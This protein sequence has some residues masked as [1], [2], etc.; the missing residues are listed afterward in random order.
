MGS[1]RDEDDHES[2][3]TLVGVAIAPFAP[4]AQHRDKQYTLLLLVFIL[5]R[6]RTA[7]VCDMSLLM[8]ESEGE[9]NPPRVKRTRRVFPSPHLQSLI[10]V[11]A[12]MLWCSELMRVCMWCSD[13]RCCHV[14]RELCQKQSKFGFYYKGGISDSA[15]LILPSENQ[16]RFLF[17][18]CYYKR[19][20]TYRCL[21]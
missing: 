8:H 2:L 19:I 6:T 16:A 12:E 20:S 14:S 11:C 15:P 13:R 4:F 21:V 5:S 17:R 9:D 1:H 7:T 10:C 3:D 18:I